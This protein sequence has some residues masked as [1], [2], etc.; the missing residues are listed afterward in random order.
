[1]AFFFIYIFFAAETIG[2]GSFHEM[3]VAYVKGNVKLAP[4]NQCKGILLGRICVKNDDK[5]C[6]IC[7][8]IIVWLWSFNKAVANVFSHKAEASRAIR[9]GHLLLD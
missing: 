9:I 4:L 3:R 6:T 8:K 5:G 1:M 7:P 2:I